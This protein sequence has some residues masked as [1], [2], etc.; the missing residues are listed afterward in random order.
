MSR[1]VSA[2]LGVLALGPARAGAQNAAGL[3]G[4]PSTWRF[5][6]GVGGSWYEN[7][8]FTSSDQASSWSTNAAPR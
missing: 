1:L 7:A 4:P 6:V 3:S 8:R 5:Q 2:G